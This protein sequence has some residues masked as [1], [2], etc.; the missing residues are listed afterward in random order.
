M[1]TALL[2]SHFVAVGQGQFDPACRS[3]NQPHAQVVHHALACQAEGN[4]LVRG[5]GNGHIK[6]KIESQADTLIDVYVNVN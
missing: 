1:E 5:K 3:R 4:A 6:S 2:L